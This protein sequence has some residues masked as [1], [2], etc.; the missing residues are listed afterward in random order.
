MD[1]DLLGLEGALADLL[2]AGIKLTKLEV[3]EQH[4]KAGLDAPMV[5]TCTLIA[6]LELSDSEVVLSN[7]DLKGAGLAKTF[8]LAGLKRKMA[9]IDLR[10]SFLRI[11]GESEGDRLHLNWKSK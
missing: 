7:F 8:A 3:N 9:E 5:G 4:L 2:P 1:L 6:D 11:W 10:K